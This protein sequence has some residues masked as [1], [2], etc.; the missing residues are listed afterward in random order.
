MQPALAH[1]CIIGGVISY[2]RT[3]ITQ[4]ANV[5][6]Y[7]RLYVHAYSM[8]GGFIMHVYTLSCS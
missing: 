2:V 6:A 3:Y 4:I 8:F 1:T 5:P 7:I